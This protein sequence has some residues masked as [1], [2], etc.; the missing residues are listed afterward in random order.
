MKRR[1]KSKFHLFWHS[2][3]WTN[4]HESHRRQERHNTEPFFLLFLL[5]TLQKYA[6]IFYQLLPYQVRTWLVQHN[7]NWALTPVFALSEKAQGKW[8]KGEGTLCSSLHYSGSKWGLILQLIFEVLNNVFSTWQ[9]L[10]PLP[11]ASISPESNAAHPVTAAVFSPTLQQFS[12]CWTLTDTLP[13]HQIHSTKDNKCGHP[14]KGSA[15]NQTYSSDKQNNKVILR[16]LKVPLLP[17]EDLFAELYFWGKFHGKKLK[18]S[19]RNISYTLLQS[20]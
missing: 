8:I 12:Q 9:I 4:A 2:S 18:F 5:L 17:N 10:S 14:T 7:L 3:S 13:G 11:K 20:I 16:V 1:P 19:L 6:F 15:K